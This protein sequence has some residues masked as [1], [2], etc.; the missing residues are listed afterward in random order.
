MQSG[1]ADLPRNA[2]SVK[3]KNE[4]YLSGN[5]KKYIINGQRLTEGAEGKPDK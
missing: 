2:R 4:K 5:A 1:L 3:E